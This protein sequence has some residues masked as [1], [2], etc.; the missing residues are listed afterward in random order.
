MAIN[1][2]TY[3]DLQAQIA[4]W[5]TPSGGSENLIGLIPTF[6]EMAEELHQF[7]DP[8]QEV[9]GIRVR[10]MMKRS[11]SFGNDTR[12]LPLPPD[13]LDMRVLRRVVQSAADDGK[14]IQVPV[15]SLRLNTG[16]N[17][18][19]YA[20]HEEI[21]FDTDLGSDAEVEMIFYTPLEA[22][23][24]LTPQNFLLNNAY[25]T[26]LYGALIHAAPYL[27]DDKRAAQWAGAY[28]QAAQRVQLADDMSRRNQG[29]IAVT[30]SG[31][32]TP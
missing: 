32:S 20:I 6:I 4:D 17:P 2:K 30:M 18:R 10:A 13:Y 16:G 27:A 8:K 9:P 19:K 28:T 24:D 22:L 11:R 12:L 15:E 1:S 31:M 26:Y 29:Q 25:S 7:G 3:D 5:L 14:L 21:E 23:S